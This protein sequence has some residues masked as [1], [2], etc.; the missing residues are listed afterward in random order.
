[1]DRPVERRL[2]A[3]LITDIVGY[4]RMVSHDE[5]GTL[6]RLRALRREI[7]DPQIAAAR[8][9]IVKSTGDGVLAE[10]PSS[11]RAVHCAVAI[12]KAAA[13]FNADRPEAE[14]MH[15]RIG[16]N[17]GDVV[18]EPDGDL[19]GDGVNVAARLEPLA[20]AGGLCISRS[21]HDQVRDKLPYRFADHGKIELKNIARPIGVFALSA[22]AIAISP[23]PPNEHEQDPVPQPGTEAHRQRGLRAIAAAVLIGLGLASG[24]G[25]WAW[26]A[27][28]PT[29]EHTLAVQAGLPPKSPPSLSLVVLP[30]ANL[31]SDPEQ[32][33]FADGLT[34]DLTTDLSH[35]AGSFV[36]ARNTAFTYKNKPVDVRQLGRDLGVRYVLEGSVRRAN[37][38][39]LLNAQLIETEAGS[40]IWSDRF[41]GE[42]RRVGEIQTEFVARLARSLDVQLVRAESLRSLRERPDNPDASDLAMRGW[43]ALN[44]I[45]TPENTREGIKYF[46]RALAIDKDLPSA[47]LG[48]ARALSVLAGSGWSSDRQA[49]VSRADDIVTPFLLA[50]PTN[51]LAHYIKGG[52]YR[53]RKQFDQATAELDQAIFYDPNF[54]D[55]YDQAG[56]VRLLNGQSKEIF[57]FSMKAI[58]LSPQDPYVGYWTF[59]ICHGHSHLAQWQQAVDW[60]NKSIS[61]TPYWAAY[62]DLATAYAW[63]DKKEEASRAVAELLKLMPGYT[64]QKWANFGV[65]DNPVF[66]EE[67]KAMVKGLKMAG[68]PEGVTDQSAH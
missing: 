58:R 40:E 3:I 37:D 14:A 54:A 23:N 48:L 11:V 12:Q 39:I 29:A 5:A 49:D 15:M 7:I 67:Y 46:E 26:S 47:Q 19:F 4:S 44:R 31:S 10:F 56:L 62:I 52:V 9:R 24:A 42:R 63:L 22:G 28:T 66:L 36:I 17:L 34:E 45:R 50:N 21:I 20:E 68:L 43:A 25:L 27:R 6:R 38:K 30:F 8:G 51:A 60:C 61:H 57:P 59:H 55:A 32:D 16:I 53:T 64:V 33:F 35:L 2:A 13:T 65:S 18:A 1:L 41:E